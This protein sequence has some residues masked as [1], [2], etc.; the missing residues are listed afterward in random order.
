MDTIRLVR[1]S[2][3]QFKFSH[4]EKAVIMSAAG[5]GGDPTL[6]S[7]K[8]GGP[9]CEIKLKAC[10]QMLTLILGDSH[11]FW[12]THQGYE[13]RRAFDRL[14]AE[15]KFQRATVV[16]AVLRWGKFFPDG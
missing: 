9:Y 5:T 12:R 16:F 14:A 11:S 6:R 13:H 15:T 3:E 1:V 8:R 10:G 7:P 2:G 4:A